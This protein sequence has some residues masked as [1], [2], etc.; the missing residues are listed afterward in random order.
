MSIMQIAMAMWL[1]WK[2]VCTMS[3]HDG[4]GGVTIHHPDPHQSPE[5]L[6]HTRSRSQSSDG[7]DSFLENRD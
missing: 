1:S 4:A 6:R 2:W 5:N 3:R 7:S